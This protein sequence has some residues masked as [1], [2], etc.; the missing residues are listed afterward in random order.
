MIVEHKILYC[1]TTTDFEPFSRIRSDGIEATWGKLVVAPSRILGVIAEEPTW[2]KLVKKL[3]LIYEFCRWK[4]YGRFTTA[5]GRI[6]MKPI[7][8][9]TPKKW[10]V[11]NDLRV[12]IPETYTFMGFKLLAEIEYALEESY[13]FLICTN[14]SS[15]VNVPALVDFLSVQDPR[16]DF[17]GG[18]KLPAEVHS[19]ISGSFIVLSRNTFQKIYQ[20][21]SNWIHA[22]LDDV[23]LLKLIERLK[24]IPTFM[25]SFQIQS[26]EG[27]EGLSKTEMKKIVHLKV[28][29]SFSNEGRDDDRTMRLIWETYF[30]P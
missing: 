4:S 10:I 21:R 27:V 23:A 14:S 19:G 3:S 1:F 7:S 13:D 2:I 11:G 12:A 30:K 24:I 9:Y 29:P 8:F 20:N 26:D 6:I 28:G 16:E 18:K 5:L 22:L 17:Y 25:N 15:F